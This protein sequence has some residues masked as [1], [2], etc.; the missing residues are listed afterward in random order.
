MTPFLCHK[1]EEKRDADYESRC[2][3]FS[4]ELQSSQEKLRTMLMQNFG[5]QT[6]CIMGDYAQVAN[7]LRKQFCFKVARLD[8]LGLI[9]PK[10]E[11]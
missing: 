10:F 6:R 7:F 9:P 5:G 1:Y 4:W 11:Y 3:Y 2:F 8:F